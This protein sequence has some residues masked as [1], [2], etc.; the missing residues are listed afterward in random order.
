[1]VKL[2]IINNDVEDIIKVKYGENLLDVIKSKGY[3]I[4]ASCGGKGTCKKCL[5]DVNGKL[6]LACQFNI[7][8][9]IT[10]KMILAKPQV[11]TSSTTKLQFEKINNIEENKFGLAID[12]GT[13]TIASYLIDLKTGEEIDS[14]SELNAQITY[15]SDVIT[16]IEQCNLGNLQALHQIVITQ[17]NK[18]INKFK[19][20][21]NISTIKLL[22]L[23]GNP[24]M[25]HIFIGVDPSS[26]GVA[27]Y[28]PVFVESQK[29]LG[30]KLNLDV[31]EVIVLPSISGYLGGDIIGGMLTSGML[32]DSS[33]SLL[34]DIG[35]N[36]EIILKIKDKLYGCSTA[37]GP[38]FEGAKIEYGMGAV[39]G[40][41]SKVKFENN[42]LLLTTIDGSPKGICG[43][44]LIDLVAILVKENII[45]ETGAF[46]YQSKSNLSNYLEENRFKFSN[47]SLTQKDIREI[48][49]AKS[50]ISAGIM[51]LCKIAKIDI[52]EINKVYLAGGFGFYLD[53][54]NAIEIGLIPKEFI[55]K[56]TIIGN[57]SGLG[58]KICMLNQQ[59]LH[60]GE[61]IAK[62]VEVIDL[63]TLSFFMDYFIEKMTF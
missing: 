26:I 58:A 44:G 10:I 40:A 38:A 11:L 55:N 61:K 47:L 46:N 21:N 4:N 53:Q 43:S 56:I 14:L 5:V 18:M 25:T 33:N 42:E 62:K 20:K 12:L 59:Y 29:F 6:E 22:S 30:T 39:S 31:E 23:A 60:F 63:S 41:I 49:L 45:D 51:T 16:R 37:A 17:I 35:T 15:G 8:N 24:T 57:S 32:E 3:L 28:Q 19:I 1:M 9:D 13:T 54:S 52:N 36:G 2:K 27:P 34:I 50:A 7:F 48:Q